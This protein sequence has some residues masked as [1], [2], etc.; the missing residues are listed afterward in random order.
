MDTSMDQLETHRFL[1]ADHRIVLDRIPS[2][3]PLGGR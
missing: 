1:N 2:E 3:H